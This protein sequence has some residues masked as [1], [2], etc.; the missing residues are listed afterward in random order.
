MS[1]VAPGPGG[2]GG[3]E[4]LD[5]LVDRVPV[6]WSEVAYDGR[7]WGLTRTDRAAGGTTSI[8]AEE[9]GGAG[10]VSANV[11]RT[12]TGRVLRPCEMPAERVLDFLRGWTDGPGAGTP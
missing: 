3:P 2:A 11:W 4:E 6:G 9:L 12:R 8:Y 7:R 5:A 1:G 10:C